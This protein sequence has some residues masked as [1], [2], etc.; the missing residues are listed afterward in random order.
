MVN[1]LH[2][3]QDCQTISVPPNQTEVIQRDVDTTGKMVRNDFKYLKE[4]NV[5]KKLL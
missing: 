1:I 5:K 2:S 3:H 4:L